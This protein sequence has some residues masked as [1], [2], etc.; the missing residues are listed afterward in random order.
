M[1]IQFNFYPS[2]YYGV[3]DRFCGNDCKSDF[4]DDLKK[5]LGYVISNLVWQDD[6]VTNEGIVIGENTYL[7]FNDKEK[8]HKLIGDEIDVA[9]LDQ[10]D[11]IE[12]IIASA[13]GGSEHI[14]ITFTGNMGEE[15]IQ[16]WWKNPR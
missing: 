12:V 15:K 13:E 16:I 6:D 11:P 14:E 8:L 1:K 9:A 4:L 3:A 10:D 2:N 5:H 7:E